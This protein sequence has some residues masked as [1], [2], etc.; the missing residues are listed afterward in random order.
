MNEAAHRLR[1]DALALAGMIG[2]DVSHE[3]R[4]VL[5]II[6]ENAGLLDDLVGIAEKGKPLDYAKLRKLAASIA[7]QVKRGTE[8]MERFSRFAH[9]ADE[10]IA[11]FDLAA[12]VENMAAL[13][14]RRVTLAACRLEVER[15]DQALPVRADAFA[16][17]H[18]VFSAIQAVL[19]SAEKSEP[20]RVKVARQGTAAAV[21]ISGAAAGGDL[22]DPT[23]QQLSAAAADRGVRLETSLADGVFSLIFTIPIQ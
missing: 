16:L 11:S 10:P 13:A 2:A 3:V 8:T 17:Q 5:A 22:S 18:L 15:P 4:N 21:C 7:R 14:Q 6:G 20:I 1:E 9:A 19:E 23:R 12:L